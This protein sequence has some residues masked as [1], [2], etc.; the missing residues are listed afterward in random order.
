LDEL[1]TAAEH[2][3]LALHQGEPITHCIDAAATILVDG[4]TGALLG[5]VGRGDPD[6][7]PG[8]VAAAVAVKYLAPA[9]SQTLGILAGGPRALVQAET[10]ARVLP[11]L[12]EIRVRQP[13]SAFAPDVIG[14][15]EAEL[16]IATYA[17]ANAA[18]AFADADVAIAI[19]IGQRVGEPCVVP[20]A[21][22][23]PGALLVSSPV[24]VPVD[25]VATSRRFISSFRGT[26]VLE[27]SVP[28][29][30]VAMTSRYDRALDLELAEAI[31]GHEPARR[32]EY[33]TVVYELAATSCA[34]L[35][36]PP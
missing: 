8:A 24:S 25:L 23:R 3:L 36:V 11:E 14:R 5:Q 33:D 30:D 35:H 18:E 12:R 9:G 1:I 19:A 31:L 28:K 17:V 7:L 27:V 6:P 20:A 10:L 2:S 32:S 15:I 26:H 4:L 13:E 21:W 22:I 34:S 16:G 29:G